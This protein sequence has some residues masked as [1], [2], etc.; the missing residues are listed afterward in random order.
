M[1]IIQLYR[2]MTYIISRCIHNHSMHP[3][4]CRLYRTSAITTLTVTWAAT[5]LIYTALRRFGCPCT[6]QHHITVWPG[7]Y[8]DAKYSHIALLTLKIF[9]HRLKAIARLT[10]LIMITCLVSIE[11]EQWTQRT[12]ELSSLAVPVNSLLTMSS[13]TGTMRMRWW[14]SMSLCKYIIWMLCPGITFSIS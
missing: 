5:Y 10:V 13:T 1:Q 7:Q 14:P 4:H 12:K 6:R 9:L 8:R 2:G 11:T 3:C